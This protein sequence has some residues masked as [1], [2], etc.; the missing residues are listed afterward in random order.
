LDLA[1]EW[2]GHANGFPFGAEE[3]LSTEN[4]KAD[5]RKS[6]RVTSLEDFLRD[7]RYGWRALRKNPGFT[8]VA[9]LTLA[10]GIGANTTIF[11]VVNAVLLRQLPYASSDRLAIIWN[12]FGSQGQSLPQVT[13][14]DLL[15]YQQASRTLD[16][17]AMYGGITVSLQGQQSARPELAHMNYVSANFFPLLGVKPL[18]GRN[19][20][21]E[22]AVQFG[23]K[24]LMI[25]FGFWQRRFG[26][27]PTAIG[28]AVLLDGEPWTVIGILPQSFALILPAESKFPNPDIFRPV[29]IDYHGPLSKISLFFVPARLKPGATFAEAQAEM[30]G[31]AD[32][33]RH[34]VVDEDSLRI[35]VV[36]FESDVVKH[37]RSTLLMLLGAVGFVLLI[38]CANVANLLLTRATARCKEFALRFALGAKSSRIVCQLLAE[39]LLLSL[40]GGAAGVALAFWGTRLLVVLRP[41][42][43]QGFAVSMDLRV[44]LFTLAACCVASVAFGI[45]QA[46]AGRHFNLRETLKEGGKS[47]ASGGN[48]LREI[49]I[50]AEI[51]LSLILLTG[52]G[53]MMQSFSRLQRVS[54][55]FQP[56]S[57]MS[58]GVTLPLRRYPMTDI[59]RFT[60]R[61]EQGLAALPGVQMV[62][63]VNALPLTGEGPQTN[64]AWDAVSEKRT[65]L[66]ADWYTV[67]PHYF[68]TIG[69]RLVAGRSFAETD[70]T[71]HPRVVIVDETL[72]AHAWPG[73]SAVGKK[74]LLFSRVDNDNRWYQV[75]G[76]VEHIRAH[77]L[78]R[79]VREQV[80]NSNQQEPDNDFFPVIR[81]FTTVAVTQPQLE[82]E[83]AKLD[84]RVPI[85]ALRPLASYLAE[86]QAPMKFSLAL[87]AIFGA[88][89][90][91]M[92]MVGIYGVVSYSV[93]RRTQEIGLR[94]AL[95]AQPADVTRV[96]VGQTL[97]FALVGLVAGSVAALVLTRLMADQFYG[98]S[99]A[100]PAI[101]I[102]TAILLAAVVLASCYIPTRRAARVDPLVALRYE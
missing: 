65:D 25:S 40:L 75:I 38:A 35:R 94:I 28:K 34:Q 18:L 98:V 57:A 70:D 32:Q 12:D 92:S 93:T 80:Y 96:I 6:R 13:P 102:L 90:L 73:E 78:R 5:V 54:P 59:A 66:S 42:T 74:L 67:S 71:N 72:A 95:G 31:I 76:V 88:V 10:L 87:I 48:R 23:P 44:L 27:D 91:V 82:S 20:Q 43:L 16:F 64:F 97:R 24:V 99:W 85:R 60:K 63:L 77:D 58:F 62:G 51:A 61:L 55:G 86:A 39:S 7:L 56:G 19:F 100:D 89:A 8:T 9:I 69:T 36:P 68:E 29:Q 41:Q 46:L 47:S 33:I 1:A 49:L 50:V 11:T 81:T 45:V 2:E 79:N 15:F 17:A 52:A 21:P 26:S 83:V 22:E 3:D 53:L 14:P 4:Y 101:H 30:D 84:P 37:I